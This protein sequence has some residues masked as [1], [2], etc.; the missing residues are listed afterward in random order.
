[1][2]RQQRSGRFG[3]ALVQEQQEEEVTPELISQEP[4]QPEGRFGRSLFQTRA[5]RQ[6]AVQIKGIRDEAI[7]QANELEDSFFSQRITIAQA[8]EEF[9]KID[10][11]VRQFIKTT[12]ERRRQMARKVLEDINQTIAS[13]ESAIMNLRQRGGEQADLDILERQ[14]V[15]EELN[16][17]RSEAEQGAFTFED[18]IRVAEAKAQARRSRA[19][20]R[21]NRTQQ[22]ISQGVSPSVASF[23]SSSSVQGFKA[24]RE[25]KNLEG[26][27]TITEKEAQ[28]LS[29]QVRSL[30]GVGEKDFQQLSSNNEETEKS[31]NFNIVRP[32]LDMEQE[33]KRDRTFQDDLKFL[34]SDLSKPFA[35]SFKF[36]KDESKKIFEDIKDRNRGTS[37]TSQKEIFNKIKSQAEKQSEKLGSFEIK[38]KEFFFPPFK[39][40]R[41]D[42]ERTQTK[43]DI[44][45]NQ[46]ELNLNSFQKQFADKELTPSEF[47]LAKVEALNIKKSSEF[48]ERQTQA[49][50]DRLKRQEIRL[51]SSGLTFFGSAVGSFV[52]TPITLSKLGIDLAVSPIKTTKQIISGVIE[53]PKT[54]AEKPFQ[55]SGELVGSF[56]SQRALARI[57]KGSNFSSFES[58]LNKRNLPKKIDSRIEISRQKDLASVVGDETFKNLLRKNMDLQKEFVLRGLQKSVKEKLDL[59]PKLQV[60]SIEGKKIISLNQPNFNFPKLKELDFKL[61][62]AIRELESR[63]RTLKVIDEGRLNIKFKDKDLLKEMDIKL[64]RSL[65]SKDSNLRVLNIGRLTKKGRKESSKQFKLS[66]KEAQIKD[67]LLSNQLRFKEF[68]KFAKRELELREMAKIKVTTTSGKPFVSVRTFGLSKQEKLLM[69]SMDK[70]TI[71]VMKEPKIE[72]DFLPK[73]S[74]NGMVLLMKEQEMIKPIQLNIPITKQK[75]ISQKQITIKLSK[76]LFKKSSSSVPLLNLKTSA[77]PLFKERS[78]SGLSFKKSQSLSFKKS[79][80]FKFASAKIPAFKFPTLKAQRFNSAIRGRKSLKSEFKFS[81]KPIKIPR[82]DREFQATSR[83]RKR[84]GRSDLALVEGFTAR[85]LRLPALRIKEKDIGK[86]LARQQNI[87]AI[88]LRP[89]IIKDFNI[90]KRRKRR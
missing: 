49:E 45:F 67:I 46:L 26:K 74:G 71:I 16:Q 37:S 90:R 1:M 56:A 63:R 11:R 34:F 40:I 65:P 33:I 50:R 41:E 78:L 32:S 5:L 30:L 20:S 23:L 4:R 14:Q 57:L 25:L 72:K 69:N 10:P 58:Q 39:D 8:E 35:E 22:L 9:A 27:T 28:S 86:A 43:L 7:Q 18:L 51:E 82:M 83:K 77:I 36:F 44:Q 70:K 84:K 2:V 21:Q 52:A 12:P 59:E 66:F 19:E 60:T 42:K 53:L 80:K 88:R 79:L 75:T 76:S 85:A 61:D 62:K 87:G 68:V 29:P 6:R 48:L 13:N 17:L 73:T 81:F 24:R 89:I 3:Q 38:I 31:F 54:F 15:I 55:T 47:N 64:G